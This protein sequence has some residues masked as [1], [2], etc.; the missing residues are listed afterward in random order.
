MARW[1]DIMA[2]FNIEIEHRSRWLHSNAD[3]LF[4]HRCKRC[5]DKK[6]PTLWKI[7]CKRNEEILEPLSVYALR[8]FP[9][10][11]S[12]DIAQM[13]A[14]DSDVKP[15]Y[16]VLAEN[17]DPSLKKYVSSRTKARCFCHIGLKYSYW[18][19]YWGDG[20]TNIYSL[21]SR[22]SCANGSLI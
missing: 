6:M 20:Q 17:T 15:V 11:T 12:I 19:T 1:I 13:Q 22:H 16:A 9:E 8:L 14:E 5:F 4:K 10:L 18:T 21:L 7:K 3:A 2:E